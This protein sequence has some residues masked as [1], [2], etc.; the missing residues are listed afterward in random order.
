ML[1]PEDNSLEEDLAGRWRGL[2]REL[3]EWLGERRQQVMEQAVLS[4]DIEH[5]E[6]RGRVLE[7]DNVRGKMQ[8]MVEDI[9]NGRNQRRG[10]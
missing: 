4:S 8:E 10:T 9:T 2:W 1:K 5:N 3:G 6:A 7:I